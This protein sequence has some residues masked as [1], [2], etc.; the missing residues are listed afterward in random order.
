MVEI[1][2]AKVEGLPI[3][4]DSNFFHQARFA[5]AGWWFGKMLFR[6]LFQRKSLFLLNPGREDPFYQDGLGIAGR[7]HVDFEKS[8]S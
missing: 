5:E 3:P 1:V 7:I 8:G 4:W 6:I 2:R